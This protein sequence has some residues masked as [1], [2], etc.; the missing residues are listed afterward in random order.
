MDRVTAAWLN[1]RGG[2]HDARLISVHIER[3]TIKVTLDDEWAAHRGL[4]KPQGQEAPGTLVLR[5][6][7]AVEGELRNVNGGWL[8]EVTVEGNDLSL[9]FCDKPALRFVKAEAWW[10][11][12]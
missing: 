10:R 1:E 8:S 5:N 12:A 4:S 6:I 9:V 3:S 11:R 2:L 7:A